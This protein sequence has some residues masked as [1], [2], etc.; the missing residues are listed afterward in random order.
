[1]MHS[2]L[3]AARFP[4]A[5]QGRGLLPHLHRA[6]PFADQAALFRGPRNRLQYS[7]GQMATAMADVDRGRPVRTAAREHGIPLRSLYHKLKMR[8]TQKS[9][10]DQQRDVV[11]EEEEE[12]DPTTAQVQEDPVTAQ[13]QEYLATAQVQEYPATAQVQGYPA[14]AQVQED[15]AT[16]QVPESPP[17]PPPDAA[18]DTG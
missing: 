1:M 18:A 10:E 3:S 4:F 12:E 7:T 2:I 5:A 13:V 11:E 16:A 17:S 14:T 15:L 9:R 6:A 8:S